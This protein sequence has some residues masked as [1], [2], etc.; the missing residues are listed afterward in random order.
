MSSTAT[1]GGPPEPL[2]F[3]VYNNQPLRAWESAKPTAMLYLQPD[4]TLNLSF[5]L[6][7]ALSFLLSFFLSS[8]SHFKTQIVRVLTDCSLSFGLV[9][10]ITISYYY[11]PHDLDTYRM[12][13][14]TWV[15][16]WMSECLFVRG[17][18][19][20]AKIIFRTS[21]L[22][23][24]F[25]TVWFKPAKPHKYVMALLQRVSHGSKVAHLNTNTSTPRCYRRQ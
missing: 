23:W 1:V 19:M 25:F 6:F 17:R 20:S 11:E 16:I 5:S 15:R 10:A 12:H 8:L 3:T 13:R 21:N 7:L 18:S 9:C 22:V 2:L 4:P 14:L 24:S